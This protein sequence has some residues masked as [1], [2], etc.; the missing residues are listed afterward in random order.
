MLIT[1]TKTYP[2]PG[3][4]VMKMNHIHH[5]GGEKYGV[6]LLLK[7]IKHQFG[8]TPDYYVKIDFGHEVSI[9]EL[10]LYVRAD[11]DHDGYWGSCTVEFSDGSTY[12]ISTIKKTA[13]KDDARR[14]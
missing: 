9:E 4:Q 13:Q 8:V 14:N 10:V 6:E 7:E 5:F 2:E 11:F 3:S 1:H 12:D